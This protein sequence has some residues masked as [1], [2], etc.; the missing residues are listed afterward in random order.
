MRSWRNWQTRKTKDLVGNT[1]QVQFL[2][3]APSIPV[4]RTTKKRSLSSVFSWYER[5]E[6]Q[7]P[8][9]HGMGMKINIG[10]RFTRAR[11][12]TLRQGDPFG[13]SA[14][15]CRPHHVAARRI[16]K[17]LGVLPSCFSLRLLFSR[18][19]NRARSGNDTLHVPF[20]SSQ[21][22]KATPWLCQESTCSPFSQKSLPGQ[23]FLGALRG[24]KLRFFVV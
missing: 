21:V 6:P 24:L 11:R 19:G 13:V 15:S 3:T 16:T 12:A 1:M 9:M 22:V 10:C 8:I 5:I 14:N 20:P 2:S 17:Q 4:D 18:G 23:I 7:P